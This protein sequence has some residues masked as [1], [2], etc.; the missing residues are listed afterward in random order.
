MKVS[1][2]K[3]KLAT[4]YSLQFFELKSSWNLELLINRYYILKQFTV[5]CNYGDWK[6]LKDN[7]RINKIQKTKK[8]KPI[9]QYVL[10]RPTLK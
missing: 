5:L 8:I 1:T 7:A 2:A 9:T 6:R 10:S 3:K 4:G